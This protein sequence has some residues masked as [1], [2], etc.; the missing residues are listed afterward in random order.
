[1]PF[2]PELMSNTT[3][4]PVNQAAVEKY[5]KDWT[6]P[7]KLVSN[8]AYQLKEW[9]VNSKLVLTKHPNDWDASRVQ[10]SQVTSPCP[11]RMKNSDV[12]LFQSGE[13][14]WVF[15]LPSGTYAKYKAQFPAD[16][17]IAPL[18]GLRYYSFNNRDP[19]L[20]DVRVRHALSMVIDRDILAQR[21]TADGQLAA[22]GVIVKGVKGADVTSL[23]L[24]DVADGQARG[25]SE[26]AARASRC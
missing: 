1:M 14:D 26:K 5:G 6:K 19:L 10:I 16:M 2:L 20:K 17:K 24:V 9:Q 3:L 11:S 4:G 7:G 13:N 25:R 18:L 23:R 22:Y 12:K 21:V 15:Q 8:G